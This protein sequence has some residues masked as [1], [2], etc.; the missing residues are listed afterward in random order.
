[1]RRCG[2]ALRNVGASRVAVAVVR[3]LCACIRD[4]D[5][6][7]RESVERDLVKDLGLVVVLYLV[8]IVDACLSEQVFCPIFSNI[9]RHLIQLYTRA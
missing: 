5:G 8:R 1:M 2:G 9:K 4:R 3:E 6:W 7:L